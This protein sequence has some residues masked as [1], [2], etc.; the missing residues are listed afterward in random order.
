[1]SVAVLPFQ[2]VSGDP[3]TEYLSDGV[4]DQIINS[5]SQVRRQNLKVR[6]FTSVARYK[7]KELDVP[8]FSRELNVQM[9]VTGTLRQ[10]GDDLAISVAVVDVREDSQLWG[11]TYR[12]KRGEILDLQDKIARDVA[13]KLRLQLTGEEE[14][15]L[16]KRYTEDPEAYLLYRE[17]TY[18]FNKV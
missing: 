16:T 11:H 4:A 15:R 9:I 14:Q 3:K 17:A 2:N 6:P 13:V 18:H 12:G 1:E 7:G 5:L 8:A 10:Q